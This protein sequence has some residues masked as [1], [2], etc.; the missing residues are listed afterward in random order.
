MP[1]DLTDVAAIDAFLSAR[2]VEP[3]PGPEA[4]R[5]FAPTPPHRDW[6][7]ELIPA[8]ARHAAALVLV[9]PGPMGPSVPLT[10]RHPDLPHHGGQ[11]SLPG[12]K[13][14]PGEAPADAALR[15]AREEIGVDPADVRLVGAL[16]SFWVIVS[17]F[18]IFPF[19]AV[20]PRRPHFQP[21]AGEV[22]RILEAPLAHVLDRTRHGWNRRLRMGVEVSFPYFDLEGHQVWGAT[23]M[24]LSEFSALFMP[25]FAPPE[26]PK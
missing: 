24:I 22:D 5:R 15:E 9:Y 6:R 2:L 23:A 10:V 19:V 8:D 25:D 21:A 7:P 1:V 14:D 13:V 3:L 18:V 12:G 11:V 4:Q 16:S 20:A 17:G 26:L